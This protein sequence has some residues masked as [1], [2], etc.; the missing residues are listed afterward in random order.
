MFK[1]YWIIAIVFGLVASLGQAQEEAQS[2]QGR[3]QT[4]QAPSQTFQLPLPVEIVEDQAAADARQSREEEARKREIAD[5]AAQEGMNAATQAMNNATQRMAEYAFWSTVLVGV[6]TALLF[7]TLYLTREAN[8]AAQAAVEV[9]D[10]HGRLQTKAYLSATSFAPLYRWDEDGKPV[11]VSFRTLYGNSGNSPAFVK[12]A[13]AKFVY[14]DPETGYFEA[15][16]PQKEFVQKST[17]H[18]QA[19]LFTDTPEIKVNGM[20]SGGV[21]GLVGTIVYQD[22]FG[23]EDVVD[24]CII[25]DRIEGNGVTKDNVSEFHLRWQNSPNF[26]ISSPYHKN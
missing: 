21:Y 8:R 17:I 15:D 5:L 14:Q 3:A 18:S 13:G 24:F 7:V 20:S 23:D 25:P 22:V 1:R 2:E 26:K 4:E 11:T 19:S 16:F 9:T 10:R 12:L 6:G